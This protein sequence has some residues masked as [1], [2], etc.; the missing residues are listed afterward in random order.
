MRRGVHGDSENRGIRKMRPHIRSHI[1]A[2]IRSH[3]KARIRNYI[4]AHIR[5]HWVHWAL[6]GPLGPQGLSGPMFYF[7]SHLEG[8]HS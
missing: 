7:L 1:K 2:H 8:P 3:I 6:L 5:S 4:E